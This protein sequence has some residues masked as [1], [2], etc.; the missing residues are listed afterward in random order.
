LFVVYYLA[1]DSYLSDIILVRDHGTERKARKLMASGRKTGGRQKGTRNKRSIAIARAADEAILRGLTPL[2]HMLNILRDPSQ[3][4][5]RRDNMAR[6]A[7][8]YCHARLATT[9]VKVEQPLLDA[10]KSA[11]QLQ[12][13]LARNLVKWGYVQPQLLEAATDGGADFDFGDDD[14]TQH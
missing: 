1:S 5:T 7:A 4:V 2:Q 9:E 11:E 13:E 8:P 14:A 12:L 10:N 3:D 6:A